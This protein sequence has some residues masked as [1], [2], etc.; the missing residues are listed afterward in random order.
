MYSQ[1]S[2][3]RLQACAPGFGHVKTQQRLAAGGD[4]G[5]HPALHDSQPQLS[6]DLLLRLVHRPQHKLAHKA[7]R[8]RVVALPRL[9]HKGGVG[10]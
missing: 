6:P 3:T 4:A 1:L 9:S 5:V 7:R 8:L 2:Q 10:G